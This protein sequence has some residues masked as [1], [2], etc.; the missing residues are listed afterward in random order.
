MKFTII[1]YRTNLRWFNQ[2]VEGKD[3]RG[4]I[5]GSS[6][7][8]IIAGCRTKDPILGGGRTRSSILVGAM[9]CITIS[10][11]TRSLILVGPTIIGSY[12]T[13]DPI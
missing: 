5:F 2:M 1:D 8:F 11:R 6:T 12:K 9:R 10:R 3:A 7:R 13:R 4:P